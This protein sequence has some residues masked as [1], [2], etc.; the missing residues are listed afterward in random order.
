MSKLGFGKFSC[1]G[2]EF[3][4]E[5][6]SSEEWRV[7]RFF[8]LNSLGHFLIITSSGG[9]LPSSTVQ[10][11]LTLCSNQGSLKSGTSSENCFFNGFL[12]LGDSVTMENCRKFVNLVLV[13]DMA[14]EIRFVLL[15][16]TLATLLHPLLA[17]L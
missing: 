16:V 10:A 1:S 4:I 15:L 14:L 11:T 2:L 5:S 17:Q 7:S 6:F 13:I 9:V 8:C 12:G 3:R